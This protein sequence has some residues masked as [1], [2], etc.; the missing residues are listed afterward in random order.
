[1]TNIT[2]TATIMWQTVMGAE[3]D[4]PDGNK[5]SRKNTHPST[6]S[7]GRLKYKVKI[8]RILFRADFT[9]LLP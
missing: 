4:N 6:G 9:E 2:I 1:M 5:K 7:D 3:G 8:H